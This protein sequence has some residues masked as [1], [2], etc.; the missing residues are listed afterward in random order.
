M[1][2][3][4]PFNFL[5]SQHTSRDNYTGNWETPASWDPSWEDP[6]T[7]IDGDISPSVTINGY[8]TSD[9][10]LS[11]TSAATN[12]IIN[13]TLVINGDL[14]LDNNNDLT[15]NDNGIL[16]IWGNLTLSNQT[17]LIT[18]GYLIVI[19]NVYKGGSSFQGSWTSN[20]YP[21]NQVKMFIGG[22]IPASFSEN[23]VEYPAVTCPSPLPYPNSG[24]S[25]G[26]IIDLAADPIYA[27]LQ[28]ICSIIN[29]Y[30]T[31]T[32]CVAETINLSSSSATTYAW[33]GPNG[34]TS[35]LQNPLIPEATL[36]MA[37]IYI[38]V[39]S[40]ASCTDTDTTI[41]NVNPIPD[42][43]TISVS[44]PVNICE[45]NSVS[46]TSSAGSAYLWST[47]A[48]LP[49]INVSSTGTYTVQVTDAQGCQSAA[50]APVEVN[51]NELPVVNAGTDITIPNGTNTTIDATVTGTGPFIYSWSPS[52]KLVNAFI[53]DPE[54]VNLTETTVLTLTATSITTS[55]SY[56]NTV[57]VSVS[58]GL[59]T[60]N[61]IATPETACAG[62]GIQLLAL[63][64]GGSG[65]YSYNWTS[66]PAGFTSSVAD[67]TVHPDVNTTYNLAVF[68]GSS[69]VNSQVV[70]TVNAL[71]STPTITAAGP[72]MICEG[73]SVILTS[74]AGTGYLWSNDATT[75][76]IVVSIPGNYTVR[77]IDANGCQSAESEVTIV[78]VNALP[79][80]PTITADGPTTFCSGETVTLSSGAGTGYLWSTGSTTA[81][82]KVTSAGSYYVQI[83]D[84]NGCTSQKSDAV[85]VNLNALPNATVSSNSPVCA[86][87]TLD[88]TSAG[89]TVYKWSGPNGFISNNQNPSISNVNTEMAGL[90][91][92]TAT[93]AQG[94]TASNTLHVTVNENPVAF[95][96]S[97][98]DLK[99]LFETEMSAGLSASETGEWTLVSGSAR[100]I[101]IHSPVTGL[102]ELG[103]GKNVFTWEVI[104]GT[105]KSSD[106]VIISVEDLFIPSVITPNGDG[107]NEFFIINSL[108]MPDAESAELIILNKW[109]SVEYRSKNYA[110]DW[111][112]KNDRGDD[113]E[114]DTYMYILRFENGFTRKG[115]VLI[116][117]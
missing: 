19:G 58:G 53:E 69:S 28:S 107:K 30:D 2:L 32:V 40:N 99:F 90:Y 44:G 111:Y 55:C 29:N 113:L 63:A 114:N 3:L 97:D 100:I 92:V 96:G 77:V 102:T 76:S 42:A 25:Y 1:I 56:A 109:G 104:S 4:L 12:L 85:Q 35:N 49:A 91:K 108:T 37:G 68:D 65:S 31:I 67:P 62:S 116:T 89:G 5:Y 54:T 95:A 57:I 88:L 22:T 41:V 13:D 75:E 43:P 112:G 74:G 51:V 84:S 23:P 39:V 71:P 72:T 93:S 47:G 73:E 103:L 48:I 46:L 20:E 60:S 18:N 50:S 86:G 79:S 24:C 14:N 11:F 78:T 98:Q 17:Q 70:V 21:V 64:G 45:G 15:I 87:N 115:T 80:A 61:P 7:V 6:P 36:A 16:I 33:S 81:N 34:F 52:E 83:I 117:R 8:I 9:G 101:D 66:T 110:N 94:C 106:D 26:N 82:I 27:F 105:C 59:L 38:L 10:S